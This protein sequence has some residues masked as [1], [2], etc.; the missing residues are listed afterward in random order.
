MKLVYI[1]GKY[2]GQNEN[3]VWE[4]IMLARK[5]AL[6]LWKQGYAVI[7]PHTNSIFMGHGTEDKD[8]FDLFIKGDLEFIKR[9]D[10]IYLL[11]NWKESTGAKME[12][13]EAKR[14]GLEIIYGVEVMGDA[15]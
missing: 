9:C 13:K 3:E 11:P 15:V 2:R 1:A 12:L 6:E 14:L 8:C 7:C 10:V 5:H 4:N